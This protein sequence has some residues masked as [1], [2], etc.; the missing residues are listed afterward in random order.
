[1]LEFKDSPLVDDSSAPASA[2]A[3]LRIASTGLVGIIDP[4]H[5]AAASLLRAAAGKAPA[6]AGLV[7]WNGEKIDASGTHASAR[8]TWAKRVDTSPGD[9]IRSLLAEH[10]SSASKAAHPQ[11]PT[12]PVETLL[13]LTDLGSHADTPVE[14][15]SP[16]EKARLALGIALLSHPSILIFPHPPEIISAK[17]QEAWLSL[18]AAVALRGHL[19]LT[20]AAP[21]APL[22]FFDSLIVLHE[23][24]LVFHSTPEHLLHYFDLRDPADLEACLAKRSG[25]EWSQ[26]WAKH[27]TTY[28]TILHASAENLPSAS[29]QKKKTTSDIPADDAARAAFL[30]DAYGRIRGEIAKFIVGQHDVIE[31]LLIA[32]LA[33]GHCLL[34]GVP[35]LAKTAIIRSLSQ[36]LQLSFRRIQFT[37]DLMPAD[38]TGTDI[39]QEDPITGHRKFVF[40]KGPLFT[41][42]LLADE[43]NRTPAKTQ[44]ALLEAMQEHS[45]TASGHTLQLEKPFFVLAT[46]NPI[47]QEGTYPLPEAQK[48]RFLFHILVGYPDREQERLVIERTTGDYKPELVPVIDG[49]Q[50]LECQKTARHVPVPP[51]VMDFALDLVRNTR[52]DS[53]T[54]PAFVKEFIGWGAGPRACQ[55]LVLA[56]KVRALLQGRFHAALEDIEALAKPVLRH[57]IVPS[58]TAESEGFTADILIE[59]LLAATPRTHV[60]PPL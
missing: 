15:L 7:T 50:I 46:Q 5:S 48:D 56:A 24:H 51:H 30:V 26:S 28:Y 55:S 53:P 22:R 23:Q 9:S 36:T 52:A 18:L 27:R 32:I 1:M 17:D 6:S 33:G 4:A 25:A 12:P 2:R 38:I 19:I 31:Q 13:E 41:Q 49:A 54:A 35:G 29:P 16:F 40:Q 34:E 59:R 60:K 11:A 47:E 57:R 37:P 14:S 42:M 58:F 45:V 3:S 39:I 21:T 8:V 44:A 20:T 43:I 10:T